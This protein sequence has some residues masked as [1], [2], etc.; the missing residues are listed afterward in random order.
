MS[1][2]T[3]LFFHLSAAQA[4]TVSSQLLPPG[5]RSV[6]WLPR[7]LSPKPSGLPW[8]PFVVWTAFHHL[9]IFSNRDYAVILILRDGRI[10]HRSCVFPR[11]FR[12]PFMSAVDLQIGDTWTCE[13]CRGQGLAAYGLAEAIRQFRASARDFW[14]LCDESNQASL[15]VAEKV[16]FRRIGHGFRT[17]RFGLRFL[18]SF[19][20][21]R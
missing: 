12:F 16:G 17:K 8:L 2:G 6:S 7:G 10:V 18:G 13:S 9:R 4:E 1:Q 3:Q 20:I 15:R 5:Y 14:Y 19:E 11:Y 21:Q